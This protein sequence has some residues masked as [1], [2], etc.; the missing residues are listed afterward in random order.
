ME[1]RSR[2]TGALII[3]SAVIWGGVIIATSYSLRETDCYEKI[4][5]ILVGGVLAHI[6][7]VWAPMAIMIRKMKNIRD[8][9][10]E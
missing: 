9:K 4:Q 8:K 5:T 6:L 10:A 3:A 2:S 7:L 1:P